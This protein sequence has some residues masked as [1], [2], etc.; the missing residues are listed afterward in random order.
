MKAINV[1]FEDKEHQRLTRLKGG[2]SWHDFI[3]EMA[4]T[5]AKTKEQPQ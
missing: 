2:R 5:T 3:L 4:E 1:T